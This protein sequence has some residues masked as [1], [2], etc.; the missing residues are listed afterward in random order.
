M[1]KR[2]AF[3]QKYL[4][5]FPSVCDRTEADPVILAKYVVALLKK[6]KPSKELQNLCTDN[7]VEFLGNGTHYLKVFILVVIV[8]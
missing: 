5:C 4:R 7:L 2:D 1:L 6:D 8:L 3:V